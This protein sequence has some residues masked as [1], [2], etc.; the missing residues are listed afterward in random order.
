[1]VEEEIQIRGLTV[2]LVDT[3][4]IQ[5]TSHPI[6]LEGIERAK[7]ALESSD[8]VLYVLDGSQPFHKED[9]RLLAVLADKPKIVVI[10]KSDLPAALDMPGL[11]KKVSGMAIVPCSCKQKSGLMA[12][13]EEIFRFVSHGK[14]QPSERPL[15]GT[16]RQKDLL[17]KA[18][19]SIRE[20]MDASREGLSPELIAVDVR[21]ALDHL[22]ALTGEVVTEDVLDALFSQFCIGK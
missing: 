9:E 10:N 2:R 15:I 14:A 5:D 1:V 4:G 11:T 18:L 3:A 16:I 19:Q 21:L 13:E 17:S 22:G 20:A 7:S 12:L 6:E 8:L